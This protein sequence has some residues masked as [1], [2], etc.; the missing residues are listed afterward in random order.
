MEK[1]IDKWRAFTK[2]KTRLSL[3][4]KFYLS[5]KKYKSKKLFF[6]NWLQKF[7]QIL[8]SKQT[9]SNITTFFDSKIK[10]KSFVF[11]RKFTQKSKDCNRKKMHFNLF[12][13]EKIKRKCFHNWGKFINHSKFSQNHQKLIIFKQALFTKKCFLSQWR[14]LFLK[15]YRAE[16]FYLQRRK[17]L[18]FSLFIKNIFE[19]RQKNKFAD[20]LFVKRMGPKVFLVIKSFFIRCHEKK[21]IRSKREY[22]SD[23][24]ENKIKK[25]VLSFFKGKNERKKLVILQ[26]KNYFSFKIKHKIFGEWAN[27]FQKKSNLLKKEQIILTRQNKLKKMI[28]MNNLKKSFCEKISKQEKKEKAY[29]FFQKKI[30]EKLMNFLKKLH[31]KNSFNKANKISI[32]MKKKKKFLLLWDKCLRNQKL[33]KEFTEKTRISCLFFSFSKLKKNT[34]ISKKHKSIFHYFLYKKQNILFG[35]LKKCCFDKIQQKNQYYEKLRVLKQNKCKKILQRLKCYCLIKKK[36]K[37]IISYIQN[38][39][40]FHVC[41]LFFEELKNFDHLKLLKDQMIKQFRYKSNLKFLQE[42]LQ[43]FKKTTEKIMNKRKYK[44][45]IMCYFQYKLL[46]KAF[47]QLKECLDKNIDKKYQL[48]DLALKYALQ[49][50]EKILFE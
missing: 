44:E 25:N 49:E 24:F 12:Y 43:Q 50:K 34:I 48:R 38:K 15:F 10:T 7:N 1:I 37:E 42:I 31:L 28:F 6:K 39:R 23:L 18:F 9:E 4:L 17:E 27:Y 41:K 3:K 20:N 47:M 46:G 30:R 32:I 36:K 45:K 29:E 40:V 21:L 26:A 22:L 13:Q 8:D 19:N 5:E 2:N 16:S 35:K 14:K 11:W 33:I